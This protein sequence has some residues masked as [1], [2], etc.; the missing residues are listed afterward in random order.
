MKTRRL[1]LLA[2]G[3]EEKRFLFGVFLLTEALLEFEFVADE[4]APSAALVFV[5]DGVDF[6]FVVLAEI[7]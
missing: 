1:A 2:G 5:E 3:L 6:F 7:V 4:G